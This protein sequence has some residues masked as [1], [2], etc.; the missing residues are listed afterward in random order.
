MK[1]GDNF[2]GIRASSLS[3]P[4]LPFFPFFSF[5]PGFAASAC[6]EELASELA[7]A[8]Q[9]PDKTLERTAGSSTALPSAPG[10]A[11]SD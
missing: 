5:F 10:S 7:P 9:R 6:Q 3:P 1:R 4:L 11:N 8:R 2:L